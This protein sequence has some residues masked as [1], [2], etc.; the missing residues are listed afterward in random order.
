MKNQ[1]VRLTGLEAARMTSAFARMRK[2]LEDDFA[3]EA[4]IIDLLESAMRDRVDVE[5]QA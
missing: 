5:A 1:T 4:T 3:R 2:L